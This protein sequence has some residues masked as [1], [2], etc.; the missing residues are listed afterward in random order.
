MVCG[1]LLKQQLFY[2]LMIFQIPRFE[3]YMDT[4]IANILDKNPYFGVQY[5]VDDNLQI[6]DK[7]R[8]NGLAYDNK[9]DMCIICLS[10]I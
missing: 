3:N 1:G 2:I 4:L 5:S 6:I 7:I 10:R 8:P 9:I